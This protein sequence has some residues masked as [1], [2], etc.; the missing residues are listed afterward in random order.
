MALTGLDELDGF[1]PMFQLRRGLLLPLL[2]IMVG[3]PPSLSFVQFFPGRVSHVVVRL[4]GVDSNSRGLMGIEDALVLLG[5]SGNLGGDIVFPLLLSST[6][7]GAW[8]VERIII[9]IKHGLPPA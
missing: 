2:V 7:L 3:I 8:H 1:V 9:T 5:P 4:M 6:A